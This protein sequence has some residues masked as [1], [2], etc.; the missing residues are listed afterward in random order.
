MDDFQKRFFPAFEVTRAHAQGFPVVAIESSVI[1][2][3]LP[4]TQNLTLANEMELA[5]RG[6]GGI[7][8]TIAVLE[9]KLIIGLSQ[10]ELERLAYTDN[11]LEISLRDFPT[12]LL[13]Q[14]NGGTTVSATMFAAQM[15]NIQVLTTGGIGGVHLERRFDVSADLIALSKT[16]MIVICA[17]A[18]SIFDLPA[19]LEYLETMG[20]P[21][22]GYQTNYFPEFFCVG[23]KLPVSVR[24]DHPIDIIKFANFHWD[25]G[26]KSA[27]LVCQSIPSNTALNPAEVEDAREKATQEALKQGVRGQKLTPFLLQQINGLTN[28][29][30]MRAN[31][32]LLSNN[33]KLAAQIA[34]ALVDFER[35]QKVL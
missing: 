31:L 12:A 13:K 15:A 29:K 11:P 3:D 17:G 33:A 20:V 34:R 35:Y 9:G 19:T 2:H 24:L 4:R 22:V 16:P 30:S 5:V 21:V 32:D 27:I 23:Q 18:K 14:A 8:A 7:P 1:T 10:T 6:E 26:M 28:G 25:M